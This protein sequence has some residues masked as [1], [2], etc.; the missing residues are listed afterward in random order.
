M[1]L[2]C[3]FVVWYTNHHRLCSRRKYAWVCDIWPSIFSDTAMSWWRHQ[4][5]TFSAL[6]ALCAGKSPITG[7][8]P[9]QRPVTRSFDVLFDLRLN[10]RLS[11]QWWGWWFET[12]SRSLWRHCSGSTATVRYDDQNLFGFSGDI[13]LELDILWP[14]YAIMLVANALAQIRTRTSAVTVLIDSNSI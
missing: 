4:M 9:A 14:S 3:N 6:L 5:E 13:T 2:G 8:I 1:W 11:K 10:K 12:P 7:E